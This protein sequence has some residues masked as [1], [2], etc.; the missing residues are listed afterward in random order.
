MA[1]MKQ[2]EEDAVIISEGE[3]NPKMYKIVS[4]K[5]A[6]YLNYG[7][8]DEYLV[9]IMGQ[10]KCFGESG[11]ICNMPSF[12]TVVAYTDVLL[13][14]YSKDDV[15]R[16]VKENHK[17]VFDI[18]KNMTNTMNVMKRNIQMLMEEIRHLEKPG[19]KGVRPIELKL[20]NYT[21]YGSG[22]DAAF[23]KKV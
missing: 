15:D 23:M 21:L 4:G 9:G 1:Q 11:P 2:F 14:P 5:A 10:H 3:I 18:M 17:D 22:E 12:Y 8:D 19:E 13:L 6:V 20:K 7:K 16:F